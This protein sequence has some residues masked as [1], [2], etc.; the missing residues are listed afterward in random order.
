MVVLCTEQGE[1]IYEQPPVCAEYHG[2]DAMLLA[3][4]SVRDTWIV[5]EHAHLLG[6]S[7]TCFRG[8][9]IYTNCDHH[10]GDTV[11]TICGQMEK[12]RRA[13]LLKLLSHRKDPVARNVDFLHWGWRNQAIGFR[14]AVMNGMRFK[15]AK[16]GCWR[17]GSVPTV[18]FILQAVRLLFCWYLLL[19][20]DS[21]WKETPRESSKLGGGER[22]ECFLV[23]ELLYLRPLVVKDW[24]SKMVPV[25]WIGLWIGESC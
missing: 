11:P 18:C 12:C 10:C 6:T 1:F 4:V 25:Q 22:G 20:S 3:T 14:E 15:V 13:S 17:A 21:L 19:K 7:P 2:L 16:M 9:L 24:S 23:K 8:I 5:R